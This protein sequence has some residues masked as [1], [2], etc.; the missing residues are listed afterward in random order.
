MYLHSWQKLFHFVRCKRAARD[1]YLYLKSRQKTLISSF[2]LPGGLM[3]WE[4]GRTPN[5]SI[6][7]HSYGCGLYVL[8]ARNSPCLRPMHR[9]MHRG[10][11][12]CT[13]NFHRQHSHW[14]KKQIYVYVTW[15]YHFYL[16]RRLNYLTVCVFSNWSFID[17]I[18][19]ISLFWIRTNM[20]N[21]ALD[22]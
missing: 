2:S 12:L 4:G 22:M 13:K 11:I 18:I 1:L 3:R 16:S 14:E 9:H 6:T 21:V 7:G 15:R 20:I 8:M 17:A 5:V 10:R 19:L